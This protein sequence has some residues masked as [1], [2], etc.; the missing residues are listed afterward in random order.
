MYRLL[1]IYLRCAHMMKTQQLLKTLVAPSLVAFLLFGAVQATF[2]F[3]EEA[4]PAQN[5]Q[6]DAK[7]LNANTIQTKP[8]GTKIIKKADG[9]TIQLH[10]DGTVL[11]QEPDGTSIEKLKDGTKIIKKPDGTFIEIKPDGSKIIKETAKPK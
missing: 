5:T 3:A 6:S 9:T 7:D 4:A 8:D 11:I 10:P 2:L 1:T